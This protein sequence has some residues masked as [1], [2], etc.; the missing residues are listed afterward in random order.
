MRYQ[1]YGKLALLTFGLVL[2]SFVILGFSRGVVE[3]QNARLL[4]APTFFAAAAL[5]VFLFVRG[6]LAWTGVR[7]LE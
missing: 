6:L 4:A 7:P 3:F 5:A 2:V 1:T